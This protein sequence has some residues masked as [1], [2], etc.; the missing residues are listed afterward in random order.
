[1]A[2]ANISPKNAT[3]PS[4]IQG[5]AKVSQTSQVGNRVGDSIRHIGERGHHYLPQ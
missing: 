2:P 1:M 3:Q 5:I 4:T